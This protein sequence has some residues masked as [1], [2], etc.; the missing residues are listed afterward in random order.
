VALPGLVLMLFGGVAADRFDRHRILLVT[1]AG[2]MVLAAVSGVLVATE[3]ITFWQI[4]L[5]S[6][7]V[8]VATAFDMPAQQALVPEL[9]EPRQI[10]Q[11]IALNQVIFNGSRLLGPALA[12]VLIAAAGFASAYFANSVSYIAVIAS[13]LMLRLPARPARL[14]VRASPLAAVGEG[15]RHVWRAP[16]VR[17][18]MAVNGLTS[19]LIFPPL[20]VL[21]TAYVRGA[22]GAGPGTTAVFF[23][24][25]GLASMLGAFAM[26]W[27]PAAR[28]GLATLACVVL[29]ALAMAVLAG[30]NLVSLGVIA[31]G[32][33]SL[34]MGLVY[35]LSA[36][37]IQQVTPNAIR[38]RV[39]SVSGLM[40]SG[41]IP[42]AAVVAGAAVE[43]SSIRAVYAVCGVAY[44][45]LAAPLLWRSGVIGHAPEPEP[46]MAG[47]PEPQPA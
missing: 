47:S 20:A 8:G 17:S 23:A 32:L 1:Q 28:R 34:G 42:L 46:A 9:V 6:T 24:A 33:L 11:A 37:T 15:L 45:L 35:G 5:V 3:L 19:L 29:Q 39:M 27:I 14:G 16:V 22:L 4:L 2:L 18:L 31:F 41:V 7:L 21:S 13:L 25:S 26:L 43:L 44:L 12:G 36:T 30:T 40:F 38:G 10:P